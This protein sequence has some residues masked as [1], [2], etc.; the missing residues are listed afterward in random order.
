MKT[1]RLITIEK[2][3]EKIKWK[4]VLALLMLLLAFVFFHNEKKEISDLVP[5][6]KA[7]NPFWIFMG[8]LS[9]VWYIVLQTLMYVYSFRAVQQKISWRDAADIFLKRN[10]LSI[11]LPAGGVTSLV[12]L[13][14]NIRK[15]NFP[16][17]AVHQASSIYG[18]VGIL[19]ILVVGIPLIAYAISINSS[20]SN[21]IYFLVEIAV[22]LFFIFILY[23]N[24]LRK[25][26][27]YELIN[28]YFPEFIIQIEEIFY[29][30]VERKYFLYTVLVSILI[31]FC[32]VL[33]V[34]LAMYALGGKVSF[35]GAALAYIISV[36]LMIVSP[37]LRGLGAVEFSMAYVLTN[38]GFRHSEGLAITLLYRFFEFWLPLVA[39]V[40]SYFWNGR[41]LVARLLPSLFIFILGIINILS[42]ITPPIATR[43]KLNELYFP[44]LLI[45][46][47]A[48]FTLIAGILLLFTAA[49][50][51]K[52]YRRAWFVAVILTAF[53]IAGNLLK[54]LDYEEAMLAFGV[55]G[56]LWYSRNE[57][58]LKNKKLSFIQG[59]SWFI[60]LFL[61]VTIMN[62]LSFYFIHPKHFGIDFTWK[63]SLYYTFH[64]FLLFK[65]N[66]LQAKTVFARDFQY[67]NQFLG[68]FIWGL[69]IYSFYKASGINHTEDEE[70]FIEAKELASK[71]GTSPMD[72]FKFS[73]EKNLYFSDSFEGFIGYR[74]DKS[75]AVV[76]E[77]PVCAKEN[78]M[79]FIKEFE[80]FCH[81]KG[82]RT[83]YYRVNEEGMQRLKSLNKKSLLIGQEAIVNA[84]KFSLTGKDKKSL[85]NAVN[86]LQKKGY[87]CEIFSAPQ[88][89]E[90]LDE[91]QK[92]SDEWLKEFNKKEMVFAEGKFDR[93]IIE[94]QDVIILKGENE[95]IK[96][97]LN[98]IPDFA[99]SE[100][101]YDL[102]RK[103]S[104]APSGSMD[105]LILT[106]I[107]YAQ[108]R[109]IKFVNM[110]MAP[111][112]G[113]ENPENPAEQIMN[114]A[115]HRIGSFKHYKNLRF[116]KEKYADTWNDM[117]FVYNSDTDLL[118]LPLTLNY[119]MKP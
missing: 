51:L 94:N 89:A 58:H 1:S 82:L 87:R 113:I 93:E 17:N 33:Q 21:N 35:I 70:D 77:E 19:S 54:A 75:F 104:D 32:G 72:Y 107:E 97:F 81:K 60:V 114:F 36:V 44:I 57:Y 13:P 88:N 8:I 38:F 46:Y 28:K 101:T 48:I 116:F 74:H 56:M 86:S 106:L 10:L 12:Y 66:G 65:D 31:E 98:L 62:F 43:A 119:I 92:I 91:L 111:M 84:E 112:S 24:F 73:D 71:F 79:N 11:F 3:Y 30:E 117:Y 108:N 20:F 68:I 27:S 76:L 2:I 6:L 55:L 85:R 67:L 61:A 53:S 25:G 4:D 102:I 40:V 42:V 39:G 100:C 95:A 64:T 37:F 80:D 15:K 105:L 69:F 22:V 45:H 96:A 9:S 5:Q 47:S 16:R 50:L 34:L 14:K 118:Q 115:Y 78:K 99:P 52:G 103:T 23:R 90:I 7:S 49:Y 59:F 109:N 26:K 63:Q 29:S 18:F 83:C 110:G 41:K